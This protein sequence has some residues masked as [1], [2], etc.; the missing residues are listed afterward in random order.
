MAQA[1]TS[2][3][4]VVEGWEQLPAGYVHR[5]TFQKFALKG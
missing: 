1:S 2:S 3:Y 4:E 5:H